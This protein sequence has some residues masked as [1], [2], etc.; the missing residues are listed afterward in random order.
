MLTWS[1]F[2]QAGDAL[3][4]LP[5]FQAPE[6]KNGW[7]WST[8]EEPPFLM[9]HHH[10]APVSRSSPS[11]SS[12]VIPFTS[13]ELDMDIDPSVIQSRLVSSST[14]TTNDQHHMGVFDYH[15]VYSRTYQCPVLY[16]RGLEMDG[17]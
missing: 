9:F 16:F 3:L 1:E 8:T 7:K 2:V 12:S 14:D 11:S 5:A 13:P 10:L 4:R 6:E 15:I 17:Q